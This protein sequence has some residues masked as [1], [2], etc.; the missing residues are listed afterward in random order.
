[1]QAIDHVRGNR[2]ELGQGR[3]AGLE[4][5]DLRNVDGIG[6][7]QEQRGLH[8]DVVGH[9]VDRAGHPQPA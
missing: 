1:M 8:H 9:V 7:L 5:V 4:M 6:S 2:G 3:I